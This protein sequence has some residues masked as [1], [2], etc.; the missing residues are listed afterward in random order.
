MQERWTY[1]A[2]GVDTAR[3]R[4]LQGRI[5]R[6]VEGTFKYAKRRSLL[7]FG[8]YASL[9][10]IGGGNALAIHTDGC[11]T[12]VLLAQMLEKY[13]TI[14]MDCVAM[15]VNDLICVGA[16]PVAMVDYLALERQDDEMV[17]EIVQGLV[18][19]ASLAGVALVG[20]ETAIMPDVIKGYRGRGFDLSGTVVGLL[21]RRSA[22]I[23]N[24]VSPG[25][26]IVGLSSSGVH[27]NGLTLARKILFRQLRERP[28]GLGRTVGEEL[29]RPT[30]IYVRPVLELMK[31][32][33]VHALAHI[34]GGGLTKLLRFQKYARAGFLFDALPE[35][36]KIFQII[37]RAGR[38]SDREMYRTFNMG[39]GMCVIVPAGEARAAVRAAKRG[40]AEAWAIG[41]V[42]RAP[43]VIVR[44]EN[45]GDLI[46]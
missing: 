42:V 5:G 21:R 14:G 44:R 3:V 19:G 13:D 27:S 7:G 20:G 25:D 12:K 4:S 35:P 43:G 33:R 6:L 32:V 17:M 28:R 46:L 31:R 30:A 18:R 15:C 40:G 8:H 37:Q 2:A 36:P 34:T 10:D 23:G 16:L 24:R 11:G 41:R 45:R 29:L 22:I 26:L 1:V 38:V 39:V 9:I